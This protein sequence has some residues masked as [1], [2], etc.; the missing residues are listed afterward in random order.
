MSGVS[1]LPGE[2]DEETGKI[3]GFEWGFLRTTAFSRAYFLGSCSMKQC[4]L[5]KVSKKY[6]LKQGETCGWNGSA[7]FVSFEKRRKPVTGS[8]SAR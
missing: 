6:A 2:G 3:S 4:R 7:V 8:F 5:G 1:S